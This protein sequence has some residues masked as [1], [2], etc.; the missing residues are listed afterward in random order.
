VDDLG[1]TQEQTDALG[2]TWQFD[3]D[4]HGNVVQTTDPKTQVTSLTYGYGGQVMTRNSLTN[5]GLA[6][7]Y[8]RNTLGQVTQASSSA[9]TYVHTYDLAHR[10]ESVTDTRGGQQLQYG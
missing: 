3:Y 2:R 1:R 9:V 10:L 8:I 6:I 4:S 7:A 5:P